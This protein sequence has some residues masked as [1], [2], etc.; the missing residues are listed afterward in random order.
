MFMFKGTVAMSLFR[1]LQRLDGLSAVT[2]EQ[3]VFRLLTPSS[4]VE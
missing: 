1:G 2:M 4:L 3:A